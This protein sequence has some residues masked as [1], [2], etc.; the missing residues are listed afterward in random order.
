[1]PWP[2]GTPTLGESPFSAPAV[3]LHWPTEMARMGMLER[4]SNSR[5][6]HRGRDR[7]TMCNRTIRR[8]GF[9]FAFGFVVACGA[10]AQQPATPAP[11]A[12]TAPPAADKP[13]TKDAEKTAPKEIQIKAEC[14]VLEDVFR[15]RTALH[16]LQNEKDA[17]EAILK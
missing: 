14:G 10:A 4:P 17:R 5:H 16:Y 2:R 6:A 7:S 13:A 3:G 15:H 1:G 12:P 11:A 9:G 8:F